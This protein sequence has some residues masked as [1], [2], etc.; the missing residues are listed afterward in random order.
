MGEPLGYRELLERRA[1][2]P[3]DVP[4]SAPLDPRCP[5]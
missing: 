1:Q 3:A 4:Q 5:Q 2:T